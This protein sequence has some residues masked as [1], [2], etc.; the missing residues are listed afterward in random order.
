[1]RSNGIG[2]IA[3]VVA[4]VMLAAGVAQANSDGLVLRAVG[5]YKGKE[6]ITD[7]Q[8]KCEIPTISSAIN[9]STN[10]TGLWNTYGAQTLFF[11]DRNNPFGDPCG[12]WLQVRNNM[13]L[14]GINLDRVRVKLRIAGAKRF[15]DFVPTRNGFPTACRQFRNQSLFV[16]G[17][18]DA[19]TNTDQSS[20]SG[21]PNVLFVQLLP[22]V[23]TDLIHCLRAQYAP[24]STDVFV[25]FPLV[26]RI[27]VE[28]TA[29]NGDHFRSNPIGYTVTL[30]HTCG[31]GRID[32]GEF[33]DASSGANSCNV[34]PCNGSTCQ[35]AASIACT[36]NA[37]C[38]GVCQPQG[39][40]MECSCL[41]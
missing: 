5:I 10:Q 18:V 1:M 41:F 25:S 27:T 14:Q 33:C 34:G 15:R 29:D 9:D 19:F 13:A 24:L 23:S 30:R 39:G 38:N 35:G 28:G 6:D 37:D 3:A 20:G 16:G 36:T 2:S 40:P 7:E 31:N 8:I 4:G 17:R 22:I 32:D 21:A 12:G 11:P 26:A